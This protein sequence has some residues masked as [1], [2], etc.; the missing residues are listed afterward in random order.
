MEEKLNT[1]YEEC[2]K[3]LS[4]IG[5]NLDEKK[6]GKINIGLAKRFTKRYGCCKQESPKEEEFHYVKRG[7]RKYKV[8]DIFQKHTIEISKWVMELDDNIIKNTII[9][10]L[11]HCLPYCNNHGKEFKKYANIINEKLKYNITRLGNKKEDYKKSNKEYKE[12]ENY[13]YKIKCKKCGYI[14]LR[15]RLKKNFIKKYRCGKCQGKLEIIEALNENIDNNLT[16]KNEKIY[17]VY[18]IRCKDNSLYTGITTDINRRMSEH[19]G[20]TKKGAKY[21][22]NHTPIKIEAVWKCEGRSSASKIESYIKKLKKIEKEKLI[23]TTSTKDFLEKGLA[24]NCQKLHIKQ[25]NNF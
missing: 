21:T 18:I 17:Y 4:S 15:K 7:R 23:I 16:K 1:L 10:E 22:K 6:I 19:L 2:I 14:Y 9:H 25:K 3:E 11:I 20:K 5:I 8:Y 13:K 12:E 24:K